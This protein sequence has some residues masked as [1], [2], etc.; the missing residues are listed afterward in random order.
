M[1]NK[2]GMLY[3]AMGAVSWSFA[4]VL[5]K[6]IPWNPFTIN[7][8]RSLFAAILMAILRKGVKVRLTRGNILGAL[9]V[10]V[11]CIL[12]MIALKFTTAA[13]AIVLQ[14]AMPVFVIAFCWI[15]YKQ[16][17]GMSNIVTAAFV[18]FG[19]ILC[20]WEGITGQAGGSNHAFGDGIALLSAVTFSL[21]FF[22]SRL[23]DADSQEY[24]Y[25]GLVMCTPFA[26][27]AFF[28]SSMT[29][30]SAHWG[31]AVLLACALG[32]GYFF[33]AK[34]MKSVTPISAAL[35]SNL[36]PI[37]NP[38]WVFMFMGENPGALTIVGAVIVLTA[39]TVYTLFGN[40]D[41]A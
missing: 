26:L 2:K 25:L 10:S 41:A 30:E 6:F 24:S 18:I 16:K 3:V 9:G 32:F 28:D 31:A 5:C 21:V 34:G 29:V 14:Y 23:P 39:A 12:Y 35:I 13:N 33:M 17:P 38:I 1:N 4:G 22:C 7:G 8:I 19:V 27:Y 36:E 15:S 40:K 11:T 37:L 20:S